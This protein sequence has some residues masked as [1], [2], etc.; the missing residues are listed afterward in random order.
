[1]AQ[2]LPKIQCISQQQNSLQ[3]KANIAA[4][5]LAFK[6]HFPEFAVFPGVA[7]LAMIQQIAAEYFADLGVIEKMEQLRFQNFIRPDQDVLID[8]ERNDLTVTFKLTNLAQQ[9]VAS[10]RIIFKGHA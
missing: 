8:F 7:Q 5:L 2:F 3:L 9:N 4:D 10:G 6:G 1:M